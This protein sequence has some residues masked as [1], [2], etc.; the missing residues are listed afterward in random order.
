VV[1]KVNLERKVTKKEIVT[2]VYWYDFVGIIDCD[3][4]IT[5]L[6]SD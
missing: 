4:Y 1:A 6:I 3:P 2:R 5:L